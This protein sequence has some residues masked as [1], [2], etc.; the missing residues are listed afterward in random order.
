[1]NRAVLGLKAPNVAAR[2]EAPGIGSHNFSQGLKGRNN[3][4]PITPPHVPPFQGGEEGGADVFPGLHPGLSHDGL[5]ALPKL[6][7]ATLAAE[8]AVRQTAVTATETLRSA[9]IDALAH[10]LWV[11][12]PH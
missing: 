4:S 12:L 3:S 11:P 8:K 10:D 7:P 1:M 6:R 5:S 2:G 9:T